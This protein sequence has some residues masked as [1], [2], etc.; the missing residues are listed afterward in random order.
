MKKWLKTLALTALA[1]VAVKGA[2]KIESKGIGGALA[3]AAIAGV[4]HAM[5]SPLEP[6]TSRPKPSE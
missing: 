4:A 5:R 3:A 6:S 2:E 1:G